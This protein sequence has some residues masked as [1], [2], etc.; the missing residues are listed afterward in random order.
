MSLLS[1]A[2]RS[3]F[4]CPR[5]SHLTPDGVL[6]RCLASSAFFTTTVTIDRT[7]NRTDPLTQRPFTLFHLSVTLHCTTCGVD[8]WAVQK[9]YSEFDELHSLLLK[10]TADASPHSSTSPS[11]SP[12]PSPYR[13][14]PLPPKKFLGSSLDPPFIAERRQ[15]LELYLTRLISDEALHSSPSLIRFLQ[16]PSAD[17]WV[18]LNDQIEGLRAHN[19]QLQAQMREMA[20]SLR[21]VMGGPVLPNG[22][23][24]LP[25]PFSST[26]PVTLSPL[27]KELSRLKRRVR[28]LE[29]FP[30]ASHGGEEEGEGGWNGV[31][32]R[33]PGRTQSQ[34]GVVSDEEDSEGGGSRGL[35][36]DSMSRVDRARSLSQRGAT[37]REKRRYRRGLGGGVVTPQGEEEGEEEE[38]ERGRSLS[39][40]H[41]MDRL[42]MRHFHY[43]TSTPY[44][45]NPFM[46]KGEKRISSEGGMGVVSS[47]KE[48]ESPLRGVDRTVRSGRHS[49]PIANH[50]YKPFMRNEKVS[51]PAS[52][53]LPP[54]PS[55]FFAAF[56]PT[57][58]RTPFPSTSSAS[59]VFPFPLSG[60]ARGV[61]VGS[62]AATAA[63]SAF[64]CPST[65]SRY[66]RGG[67]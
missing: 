41:V 5:H 29:S 67:G 59:S 44:R 60:Q 58:Q 33:M 24:T 8:Q 40:S 14:P 27:L 36:K 37:S 34:G 63:K 50:Y 48:E 20:A 1:P 22:H 66:A 3:P 52:T 4:H 51:P 43:R 16:H 56:G 17:V 55:S 46:Q 35:H 31:S 21:L 57:L 62:A 49:E 13:L 64:A 10:E 28:H 7:D 38:E 42:A 45:Q 26:S 2:L 11:P 30:S 53:I 12:S 65:P 32:G 6:S 25:L 18:A 19:V 39:E 61:S 47:I 15:Q 54:T 9:R 23:L